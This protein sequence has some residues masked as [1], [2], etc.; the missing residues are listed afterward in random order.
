MR[1]MCVNPSAGPRRAS[2]RTSDQWSETA[3]VQKQDVNQRHRYGEAHRILKPAE[4][5]GGARS[6]HG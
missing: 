4:E 6:L 1:F 5:S 2:R 3:S